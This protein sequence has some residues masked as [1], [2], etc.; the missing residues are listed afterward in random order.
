MQESLMMRT[1]R[2]VAKRCPRCNSNM[3]VITSEPARY[4]EESAG[5]SRYAAKVKCRC[6]AYP[7]KFCMVIDDVMHAEALKC[8]KH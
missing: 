4:S 2:E 1:F 3:I 8:V 6:C 5:R 7:G